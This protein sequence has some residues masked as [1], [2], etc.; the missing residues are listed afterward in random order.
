MRTMKSSCREAGKGGDAG[1]WAGADLHGRFCLGLLVIAGRAEVDTLWRG[2]DG[3]R[4]ARDDRM[5]ISPSDVET[6]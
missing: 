5:V 2:A 6:L 4:H 3:H 1:L